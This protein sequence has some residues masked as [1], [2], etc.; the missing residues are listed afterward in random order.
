Q[1]VLVLCL[2]APVRA[3]SGPYSTGLSNTNPGAVDP[4]VPGFINGNLNPAF[5]GWATGVASYLPAPGVDSDWSDSTKALH[6][7]TQQ[8]DPFDIVSL[9]DLDANQIATG[10]QPGQITLSFAGGIRNQTGPDFSVFENALGTQ[11]AVF[12]ELAYVEVSSDGTHFARFP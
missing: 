8:D 12:A 4:A 7:L 5:V 10:T 11:N 3:T 9:G 2:A 1:I 6:E